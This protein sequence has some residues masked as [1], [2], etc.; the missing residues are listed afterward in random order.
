MG[1][2]VVLGG[3]KEISQDAERWK[4]RRSTHHRGSNEKRDESYDPRSC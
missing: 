4:E 2:A 3:E 1:K